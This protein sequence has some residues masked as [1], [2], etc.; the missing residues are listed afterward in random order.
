LQFRIR[1]PISSE[2]GGMV[3]SL[4]LTNQISLTPPTPST[5]HHQPI[6]SLFQSSS[7]RPSFHL[8]T[9]TNAIRPISYPLISLQPSDLIMSRERP[10]QG[11]CSC[12]RNRYIIQ[13]PQDATERP[14]VFFDNSHSHRGLHSLPR[15]TMPS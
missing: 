8:P 9:S 7:K 15:F 4:L 1:P 3:I 11:G 5:P 6:R 14:Q 10:L 13:I 12:G 2:E